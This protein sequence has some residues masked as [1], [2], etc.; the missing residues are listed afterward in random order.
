MSSTVN[1]ELLSDAGSLTANDYCLMSAAALLVY[2]HVITLDEE[3]QHVQKYRRTLAFILYMANRYI[4]L[5]TVLYGLPLWPYSTKQMWSRDHTRL[6]FKL[7]AILGVGS[8]FRPAYMGAP[9][10]NIMGIAHIYLLIIS[11]VSE[12]VAVLAR[13]PLIL[14]DLAVVLITW[15]TQYAAYE[16]GLVLGTRTDLTTVLLRNGTVYFIILTT[17]NFLQMILSIF[18][19]PAAENQTNT[20]IITT[21][22][23]PLTA[24]LISSFLTDLHNAANSSPYDEDSQ[25]TVIMSSVQFNAM[26]SLGLALPAPGES[27]MRNSLASSDDSRTAGND[28]R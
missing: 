3:V 20:N 17:L 18:S 11:A 24:I 12:C 27:T 23:E 8:V 1:S 14:A 22:I 7:S 6:L 16:H 4:P 19:V 26:D 21:F 2:H 13:L 10:K 5:T 9:E 25:S 15:S 28:E